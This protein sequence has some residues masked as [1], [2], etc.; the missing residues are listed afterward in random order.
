MNYLIRLSQFHEDFRLPELQ[1]LAELAQI[2]TTILSYTPTSPILLLTAPS[3][4]AATALIQRAILTQSV[5]E[6]WA[7]A[8][9]LEALH[10]AIKTNTKHL[11]PSHT[12]AS[13]KFSI[14]AFQGGASRTPAERTALINTFRYLPLTGPIRMTDPDLELTIFEE[15]APKEPYPHT[16]HFGRLLARSDARTMATKFDLK[17]RPYISTTS[18]AADLTLITANLALAAPGKLFYDP[19]AGTGSFPLA[20]AAFGA[21]SWGS[22]IDGRAVRGSG[23]D[24]RDVKGR[25]RVGGERTVRGNFVFYGLEAGL[26]DVFTCDLTNSPLRRVGFRQEEKEGGGGGGGDGSA[27]R[28]RLFDGVV[29][30]PPYGVREGLRVLG[31]KDPEGT[32]WI[33]EAGVTKYK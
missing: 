22:D 8:T 17:K 32:P 5:Y 26:G 1:A 31:C 12:T 20:S 10:T 9:T 19:F 13:W 16:Y 14:D 28:R 3:P 23:N 11:W 18:M 29:C 24:A 30:D 21:V 6:H 2:P 25:G 4:A 15:Y 7:T 27:G 33:V